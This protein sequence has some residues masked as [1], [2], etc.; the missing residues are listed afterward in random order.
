MS[1]EEAHELEQ[2]QMFV[3]VA[4]YIAQHSFEEFL[5]ALNAYV[6]DV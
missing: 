2:H 4:A 6:E 5:M 3:A 1:E